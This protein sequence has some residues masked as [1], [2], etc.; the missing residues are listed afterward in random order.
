M[1]LLPAPVVDA[2]GADRVVGFR[3]EHIE[4]GPGRDAGLGFDARV[5]VVEYLGD[6]QIAHLLVKDSPVVA[7]LPVEDKLTTG[8]T[9]HFSVERD[10]LRLF[11]A[12][13]QERVRS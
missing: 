7:K 5:E 4:V 9:T 6:E 2:G 3:P 10:K 13:T 11:E 1:N 8:E 12:E